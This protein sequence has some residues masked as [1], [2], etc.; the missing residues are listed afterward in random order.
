MNKIFTKAALAAS[1]AVISFG[2]AAES[3]SF[4]AGVA[5]QNAFTMTKDADL[6]F[7]TI[8]AKADGTNAATL[9]LPADPNANSSTPAATDAEIS[10]LVP[11]T[12]ASFSVS[13]VSPFATLTITDPSP[14]D[15]TPDA[16]PPGTPGFELDTYTYYLVSGGASAGT[17]SDI[18]VDA[19]GEATF[20]LGATLSTET[21][22]GSYIDGTYSGTF[23]LQ[24]DY[25]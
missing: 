8:R 18:Q 9:I 13:G 2:A 12:P 25:P 23:T 6:D 15:I 14:A 24:L 20:N 22:A 7:G 5:V 3:A 17:V 11:G 4:Q 1:M 21:V 16:A 19:N 10:I